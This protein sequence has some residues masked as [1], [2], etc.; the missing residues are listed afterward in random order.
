MLTDLDVDSTIKLAIYNL[1]ICLY[2]YGLE[3]VHM[4]GLMRLLGVPNSVAAGH[5][6]TVMVLNDKVV[7]CVQEMTKT[8]SQTGQTLH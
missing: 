5:D 1:M 3:E 6:D 7:D 4:G 2:E 8:A